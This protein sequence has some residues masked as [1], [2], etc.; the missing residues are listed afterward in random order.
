MVAGDLQ[1]LVGGDQIE[2]GIAYGWQ[3]GRADLVHA[4]GTREALPPLGMNG[5]HFSLMGAFSNSLWLDAGGH[6]GLLEL[7]QTVL[8]DIE[9][10]QRIEYERSLVLG[11]RADV[12]SVTDQIWHDG[13]LYSGEVDDPAARLDV[14]RTDG[15]PVTQ[16][17]PHPDGRFQFRLPPAA[18]RPTS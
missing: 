9:V 15:T 10:G 17:R 12:A 11:D 2:P 18:W 5:E 16:V 13:P 4:D 1:V 7:S 3:L 8:M 14:R 6:P